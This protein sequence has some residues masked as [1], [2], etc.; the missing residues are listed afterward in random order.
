MYNILN[1][2]YF[3]NRTTTINVSL[4]IHEAKQNI[5]LDH[6]YWRTLCL[7]TMEVNKYKWKGRYY[8]I[9]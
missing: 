3:L 4:Y 6:A 2:T 9:T 5:Y 8:Y 1:M 7:S